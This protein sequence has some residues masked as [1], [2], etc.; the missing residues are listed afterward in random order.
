[1]MPAVID[2]TSAAWVA[3][4]MGGLVHQDRQTQLA[5]ANHHDGKQPSHR[6]GCPSK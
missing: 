4:T 5:C 6:V 3:A 1:M 2:A